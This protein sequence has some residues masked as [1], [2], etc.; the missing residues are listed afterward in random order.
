MTSRAGV[1]IRKSRRRAT[2]GKLRDRARSDPH[3]PYFI[4]TYTINITEQTQQA[5]LSYSKYECQKMC[6]ENEASLPTANAQTS[7]EDKNDIQER[8]RDRERSRR[9][10]RRRRK[11]GEPCNP[12]LFVIKL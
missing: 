3:D 4:Y 2:S 9:A 12:N 1:G 8:R 6:S 10:G 11:T 7:T 5:A